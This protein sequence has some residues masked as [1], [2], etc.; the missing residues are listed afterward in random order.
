M[1]AP[2]DITH[3]LGYI[4]DKNNYTNVYLKIAEELD[5]RD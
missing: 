1:I 4:T 3:K 5:L 2:H